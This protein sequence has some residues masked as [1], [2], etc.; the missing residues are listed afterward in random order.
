MWVVSDKTISRKQK[1]G[2]TKKTVI[3]DVVSSIVEGAFFWAPMALLQARRT[4]ICYAWFKLSAKVSKYGG[5]HRL[6]ICC[7]LALQFKCNSICNALIHVSKHS[8]H[9]N[10]DFRLMRCKSLHAYW[11]DTIVDLT[12]SIRAVGFFLTFC[13]YKYA[14][15]VGT[16]GAQIRRAAINNWAH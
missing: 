5:V 14:Y 3:G 7:F 12:C 4:A 2:N 1:S 9:V 8:W 13:V 15:Y 11:W 6:G 16:W 10:K